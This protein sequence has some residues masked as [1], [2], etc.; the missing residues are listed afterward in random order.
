M[1]T[2]KFLDGQT[3]LSLVLARSARLFFLLFLFLGRTPKQH[4]Y[5]LFGFWLAAALA[6]LVYNWHP[7]SIFLENQAR[8]LLVLCW[9]FCLLFPAAKLPLH[10][11]YGHPYFDVICDF[12]PYFQRAQKPF[13]RRPQTSILRLLDAGF[14]TAR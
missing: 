7:A 5:S 1:Y 14:R 3:A 11:D 4:L 10:F 9:A 8:F 2:T 13:F 6:F 12:P